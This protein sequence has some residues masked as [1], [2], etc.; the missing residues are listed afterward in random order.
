MGSA[1]LSEVYA[2]LLMDGGVAVGYWD[3]QCLLVHAVSSSGVS[4]A[5][6]QSMQLRKDRCEVL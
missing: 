2:S 6:F 5:R 1:E 3:R 4:S